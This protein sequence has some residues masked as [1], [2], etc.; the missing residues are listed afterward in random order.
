MPFNLEQEILDATKYV[1]GY[2]NEDDKYV[3]SASML[4]KEP[5]ENYLSI[6]YGKGEDVALNDATLG[7]VFH[8]GME[9]YMQEKITS[10]GSNIPMF[11]EHSMYHELPNGWILSGTA[12]LIVEA[13]PQHFEI[14]DYKLTK[15]YTVKMFDKEPN[16]TYKKQMHVLCYLLEKGNPDAEKITPFVDFF[17]KDSKAINKEPILVQKEVEVNDMDI[18]E[19]EVIAIT[20]ELQEYIE[21]GTVPPKCQDTWPRKANGKL[22]HTKC[23]IY[24][25]HKNHCP[26]Y[27][28]SDI[29]IASDLANW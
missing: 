21:S 15:N 14:H 11:T 18:F 29:M 13:E 6:I 12:D 22:V 23:E 26:H 10:E 3:I 19:E 7:T 17:L 9:C 1:S 25:A 5:L 8:K 4:G 20:N 16:H 2:V 27:N 24:C 28:K